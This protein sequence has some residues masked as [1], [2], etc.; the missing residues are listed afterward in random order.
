MM[1]CGGSDTGDRG[2]VPTEPA[3]TG[4]TDLRENETA[5][6]DV[7][8]QEGTEW[9]LWAQISAADPHGISVDNVRD[10][11]KLTIE[12]LSGVAY[13]SGKSGWWQV[14][15]AVYK[16]TAGVVPTGSISAHVITAISETLPGDGE[17]E[18]IT[19]ASKP[20]DA[21]GRKL[22]DNLGQFAE[23]EGGIVICMPVAGGPMY[24]HDA[25]HFTKM[26]HATPPTG[27]PVRN[28]RRGMKRE[29]EMPGK[30]FPATR[31]TTTYTV[32]GSGVLHIYA[33]DDNYRDNAGSYEIK[34]RIERP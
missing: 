17:D 3:E 15:S 8:L 23:G 9:T 7:D 32:R 1:G 27:Q 20:R 33:F 29:S 5:G 10:E 2:F 34:F 31:G 26:G 14:L 28:D 6:S 12:T 25:N 18:E 13:F 22:D 4:A 11:D 16:V 24:A 21:Y 30:C 19:K